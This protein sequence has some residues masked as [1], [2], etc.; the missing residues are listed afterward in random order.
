ME[1][2][3]RE[4]ASAV[5]STPEVVFSFCLP[6]RVAPARSSR[7]MVTT[8]S[9]VSSPGWRAFRSSPLDSWATRVRTMSSSVS[10]SDGVGRTTMLN[11]RFNAA[12][13]SLTPL[14]RVLAVAMTEKPLAA[15]TS[16]PSSGTESRFSDRMEI[17]ASCTSLAQ[18]EISST[19]AMEPVSMARYTGLFTMASGQGPRAM[20]MA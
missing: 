2:A 17:S 5:D 1:L 18:R 15:G 13:I 9:T 4:M 7:K 16:S 12:D 20:S 6:S 19:R 11:R 10:M 8:F 14:S 3:S